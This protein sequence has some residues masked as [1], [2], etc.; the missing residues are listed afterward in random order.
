M[1]KVCL[2]MSFCGIFIFEDLKYI[3]CF[4]APRYDNGDLLF[5]NFDL[6]IF[7]SKLHYK[8]FVEFFYIHYDLSTK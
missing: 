3:S 4:E 2:I 7:G 8:I 5:E 1:G 6:K